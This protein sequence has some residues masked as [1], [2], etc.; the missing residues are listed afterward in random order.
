ME[1]SPTAL[2]LIG[3]L[4]AA[5]TVGAAVVM[6][7][8]NSKA[9]RLK[10]LQGSIKRMQRMLDV[11]PAIPM[12]SSRAICPRPVPLLA[13]PFRKLRRKASPWL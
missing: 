1:I 2:G 9:R 11:A 13:G 5:W 10:S 12:L 8:A 3:L 7:R 4:L 6:L